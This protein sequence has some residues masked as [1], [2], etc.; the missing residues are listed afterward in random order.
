MDDDGGFLGLNL[1][2]NQPK[3]EIP[4]SGLGHNSETTIIGRVKST[5][6]SLIKLEGEHEEAIQ[7][8]VENQEDEREAILLVLGKQLL[9]GRGLHEGDREF[10]KWCN[11]NFPNLREHINKDDQTAILW[12][13][14]FPEQ[15]QEML[16]KHPRVRTTRGLYDKWKAQKKAK[17][18]SSEN[19]GGSDEDSTTDNSDESTTNNSGNN[20]GG[21]SGGGS[22]NSGEPPVEDEEGDINTTNPDTT[23]VKSDATMVASSLIG[24]VTNMLM[25]EQTQKR[26]VENEELASAIF[27]EIRS[28]SAGEMS[29]AEVNE[30]VEQKLKRVLRTITKSLS[31]LNDVEN[32]VVSIYKTTEKSQ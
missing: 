32:N 15:H 31:T 29:D 21:N 1:D 13:A 11:L 18:A 14:E 2:G 28:H 3:M 20:T 4:S 22:D 23:T 30:Y 5:I 27:H 6:D 25:F 17:G 19:T 24:V 9:E 16:D 7:T 8:L 10:G 12:A 26:E